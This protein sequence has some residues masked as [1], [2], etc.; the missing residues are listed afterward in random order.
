M[1]TPP[2]QIALDPI[3]RS[4]SQS[5]AARATSEEAK[6]RK[7]WWQL[8]RQMA[9]PSSS[10][11]SGFASLRTASLGHRRGLVFS[12]PRSVKRA[13]AP[14]ILPRLAVPTTTRVVVARRRRFESAPSSDLAG[15]Y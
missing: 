13:A 8:A 7:S 2:T 11:C 4:V 12:T 5:K 9:S 3:T 15:G 1:R 10:L 14:S 6:E